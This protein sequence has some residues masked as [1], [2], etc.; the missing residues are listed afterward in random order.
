MK[1]LNKKI[2]IKIAQYLTEIF[3]NVLLNFKNRR[4][5][6]NKCKLYT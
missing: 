3:F 2:E 4:I 1:I 6:F 5:L